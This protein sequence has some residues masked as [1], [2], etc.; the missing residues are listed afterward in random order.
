MEL[1]DVKRPTSATARA[2]V[3]KALRHAAEKRAAGVTEQK[4][5]RHY[6]HAVRLVG[7]CEVADPTPETGVWVA[8]VRA[9]Y[10]RYPALQDEFDKCLNRR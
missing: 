10:R 4:R 3:V 9:K 7:A 5:R 6:G 2:L 8:S 1:A